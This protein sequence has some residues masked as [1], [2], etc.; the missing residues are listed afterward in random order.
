M[1]P[2]HVKRLVARVLKL[3][4]AVHKH[5]KQYR[6]TEKRREAAQN[7]L[8]DTT[9]KLASVRADLEGQ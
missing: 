7:I 9:L 6:E 3:E 8:I 5:L 1:K 2:Y 4:Q